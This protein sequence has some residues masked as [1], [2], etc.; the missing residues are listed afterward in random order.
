LSSLNDVI[1]ITTTRAMAAMTHPPV[2]V[3]AMLGALALAASLLAGFGM[4]GGKS[5]SWLHI[6]GFAAFTAITMYVIVDLEYPRFG[7]IRVEA[8]DQVLVE[9]RQSMK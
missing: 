6:V 3:F 1:D 9:L 4:A 8:F 7:L 5:R 2:I